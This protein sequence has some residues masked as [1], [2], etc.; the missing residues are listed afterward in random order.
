MFAFFVCF[1]SVAIVLVF[2]LC[3]LVFGFY[4]VC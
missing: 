4:L 2:W 1:N 3:M